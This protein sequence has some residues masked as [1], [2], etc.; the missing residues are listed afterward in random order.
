MANYFKT[1]WIPHFS[2]L[3]FAASYLS[4]AMAGPLIDW[5]TPPVW[6]Q[7]QSEN[8]SAQPGTTLTEQSWIS[9]GRGGKAVV[10][11]GIELVEI[12]ENSLWEWSGLD[13]GSTGS[14]IQGRM[15]VSTAASKAQGLIDSATGD[16]PPRLYPNAPWR[17]TLDAG[18]DETAAQ[19][20]VVFL[21]NS[22]YPVGGTHK[23]Q[24]DYGL[25]WQIWLE[26]FQTNEAAIT[27]G[28][29]LMALAPAIFSATPEL[30]NSA[31]P[32]VAKAQ[33]EGLEKPDNKSEEKTPEKAIEDTPSE[34]K[35]SSSRGPR[36]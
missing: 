8:T 9:T 18:D 21:K 28:T 26:G 11:M 32:T 2:V 16:A 10:M 30:K 19:K 17:L 25:M 20:L 31:D 36:S 33:A 24:L 13:N 29:N 27:I 7:T 14:V 22:G 23:T 12:E 34:R 35:T 5:V 15:R 3:S 6:L 1:L 4:C